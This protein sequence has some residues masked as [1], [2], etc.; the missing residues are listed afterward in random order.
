MVRRQ[1]GRFFYSGPS[2]PARGETTSGGDNK[3]SGYDPRLS[4]LRGLASLGVVLYHVA[5]FAPL[6]FF[7]PFVG[8]TAFNFSSYPFYSWLWL[9]VPM[10]F[11]LSMFLLLRSLD[12]NGS[13]KH[14]YWRR[15]RRIWPIYFG[16]VIAAWFLIRFPPVELLQYLTFTNY[17]VNP[18]GI[19][20][21]G[22]FWTLQI[23]EAMYL[24]IPLIH[25]SR[26]K[27]G[28]ARIFIGTSVAWFLVTVYSGYLFPGSPSISAYLNNINNQDFYFPL[29]LASYGVGILAY[30]Q[31]G[32]PKDLRW[33]VPL[34]VANVIIL[35]EFMTSTIEWDYFVRQITYFAILPG[36][37]ALLIAP[38]SFLSKLAVVGE[39]SYAT[40]ATQWFFID[41]IGPAALLAV[42]VFSFFVEL[43]LRPGEIFRRLRLTYSGIPA[44][45]KGR[46]L[47]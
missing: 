29:F 37:G 15:I 38:P 26:H 34:V 10:F 5:L 46:L 33:L 9:G 42:P 41:D 4:G 27:R 22:V 6:A 7:F 3:R 11:M 12:N 23:E 2:L 30:L 21:L 36:L 19:G 14:Y 8:G 16:C 18:A 24:F 17:W 35:G 13:L 20:P 28:I 43:A 47:R 39:A 32:Y 31:R 40:Y 1:S 45:L 44:S 25:R